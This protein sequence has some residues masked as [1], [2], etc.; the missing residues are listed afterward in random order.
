MSQDVHASALFF[1]D[2]S[3]LAEHR[4]GMIHNG[5]AALL[6]RGRVEEPHLLRPEG[7][8]HRGVPLGRIRVFSIARRL[9]TARVYPQFLLGAEPLDLAVL[10]NIRREYRHRMSA[11]FGL[12][13]GGVA[14]A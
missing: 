1:S 4:H 6:G 14:T 7:R 5:G 13:R 11:A 10:L 3:V 9:S 12:F 8:W 2:R